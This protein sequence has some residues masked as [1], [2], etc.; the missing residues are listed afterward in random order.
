M[1]L[2][3]ERRQSLKKINITVSYDSEKIE[4]LNFHLDKKKLLLQEEIEKY[5]AVLYSKNVPKNIQEY[6][7]SKSKKGVANEVK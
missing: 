6:I 4:V 2:T 7:E 5:I 1:A 3:G